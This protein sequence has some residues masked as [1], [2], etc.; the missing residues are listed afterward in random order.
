MDVVYCT[1]TLFSCENERQEGPKNRVFGPNIVE[2]LFENI[3]MS[4]LSDKGVVVIK[5]R[6]EIFVELLRLFTSCV[7]PVQ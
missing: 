5:R 1:D 3:G 7:G 6:K 4:V 2:G